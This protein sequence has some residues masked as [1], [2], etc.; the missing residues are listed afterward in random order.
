MN[1]LFVFEKPDYQVIPYYSDGI[2]MDEQAELLHRWMRR[3][4]PCGVMLK[5]E[6]KMLEYAE[7]SRQ[8]IKEWME[9]THRRFPLPDAPSAPMTIREIQEEHKAWVAHNFPGRTSIQ[10]LLGI[11]EEAGELCHAVLKK[12]QG[13]RTDEDH[14][15]H[16]RDAVGDISIFLLDYCSSR[17]WDFEQIMNETWRVV[18]QRD[19]RKSTDGKDQPK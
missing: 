11:V 8:K 12:M 15:A 1:R 18:R 14:D 16:E 9:K 3:A 19:W 2:D 13:I 4:F 5:L 7:D 10:P 6:K 17:G